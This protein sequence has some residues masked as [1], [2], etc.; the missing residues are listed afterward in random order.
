MVPFLEEYKKCAG[1]RNASIQASGADCVMQYHNRHIYFNSKTNCVTKIAWK[2]Q[3]VGYAIFK[4]GFK[5]ATH[6]HL[7]ELSRINISGLEECTLN[8]KQCFAALD[9]RLLVK[10]IQKFFD[11][12]KEM[13]LV[14]TPILD[15]VDKLLKIDG[16]LAAKGCGAMS[17]DTI[18]V[19]Y[20]NK[21]QNSALTGVKNLFL[22]KIRE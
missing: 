1:D 6:L 8:V 14:Y 15:I 11:I 17:A 22:Q 16:I 5:I 2:F 21:L 3:D 20:D 4:T 10:N 9:S 7:R 12:L 18:L 19:I 13:K